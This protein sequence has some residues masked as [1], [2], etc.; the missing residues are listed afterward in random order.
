MMSPYETSARRLQANAVWRLAYFILTLSKH[1][2][3]MYLIIGQES[4]EGRCTLELRRRS[5][6]RLQAQYYEGTRIA[7]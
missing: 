5:L 7:G 3:M 6:P 1:L 4:F 2:S